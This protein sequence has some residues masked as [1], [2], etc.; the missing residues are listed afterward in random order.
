V[1]SS[2]TI[3]P[4]P[5]LVTAHHE[6]R[7]TCIAIKVLSFLSNHCPEL[8]KEFLYAMYVEITNSPGLCRNSDEASVG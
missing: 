6:V 8:D 7:Y 4:F 1:L 2:C 5:A 3:I